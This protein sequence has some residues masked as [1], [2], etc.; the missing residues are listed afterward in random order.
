MHHSM[1]FDTTGEVADWSVI[2]ENEHLIP[3]FLSK[4]LT[5]VIFHSLQKHPSPSDMLTILV[6]SEIT[7]GSIFF[8]IVIGMASSSQDLG[9]SEVYYFTHLS[10][11]QWSELYQLQCI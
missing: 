5:T 9:L 4:G 1:T 8:S 3:V 10:L 6:I 2:K 7:F 11:C